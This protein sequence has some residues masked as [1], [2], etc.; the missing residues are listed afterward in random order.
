MSGPVP[1]PRMNG[2]I[3]FSGTVSLPLLMV[4]FPPAGGVM[5][6]YAIVRR[7][8]SG[9]VPEEKLN[10]AKTKKRQTFRKEW[11]A[12]SYA[13]VPGCLTLICVKMQILHPCPIPAFACFGAAGVAK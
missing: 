8:L 10:D 12:C 6:L 9:S 7:E 3:G 13:N 2:K 11:S 5:S 1:S 4:I